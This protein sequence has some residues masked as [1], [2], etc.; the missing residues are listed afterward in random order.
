MI[1]FA[2]VAI[3]TIG[4]LLRSM[5]ISNASTQ[6][7]WEVPAKYRNMKNP[8]V[9]DASSVK[10]GEMLY[11]KNCASC[12]GKE[13]LGD[14]VKARTLDTFPGDLS[15]ASYQ[16]QADGEHFFKT[17]FGHGEMPAFNK[18]ISDENGWNLVNY[19]RTF[20]Q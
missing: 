7:T 14:G 19:M 6:E 18:K 16:D 5:T 12:H 11:N 1:L 10:M 13:G 3:L 8:V 4:D 2:G 15:G 9:A 20:K 17:K